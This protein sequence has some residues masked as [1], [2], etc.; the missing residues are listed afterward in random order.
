M[1]TG[2]LQRSAHNRNAAQLVHGFNARKDK[3][4]ERVASPQAGVPAP[5]PG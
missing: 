4:R 1:R 3:N 2:A 5:S